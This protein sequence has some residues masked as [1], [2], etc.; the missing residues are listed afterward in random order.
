MASSNT[1]LCSIVVLI[2][3]LTSITQAQ[4]SGN[5]YGNRCPELRMIVGTLVQW[6]VDNDPRVAAEM[7]RLHFHDCFVNG[8]DASVLLDVPNGEKASVHNANSLKG[9][10]FI[11]DIKG[12]V[13]SACP[14]VVSCADIISLAAR[15]AVVA[16]GGPT[17]PVLLGRRD[18]TTAASIASTTAQLP[19]PTGNL[20]NLIN[21]FRSKGFSPREMVALSGAHTIGQA[22]CIRFR[23]RIYGRQNIATQFAQSMQQ[24][25]PATRGIDDDNLGPL[26]F[27]TPT[28]FNNDYFEGLIRREGLLASDQVLWSSGSP[29]TAPV[30]QQYANDEQRFFQ[31]FSAAMFKMSRLGVKTGRA[32]MIRK[33]CRSNQR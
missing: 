5:F 27:S 6:T 31:D 8:C 7:L 19:F 22:K 25:C 21:L 12:I 9:F 10:G 2:L 11:D 1:S 23:N 4:L 20:G 30:V 3:C 26:D 17:W 32:G 13:E 18:S 15:D 16:V 33:N 28:S 24:I 14:G 29:Q